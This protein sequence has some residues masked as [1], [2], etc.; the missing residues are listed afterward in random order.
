MSDRPSRPPLLRARGATV[1]YGAVG[2]RAVTALDALDLEIPGA[3]ITCLLGANGAGKTTLL[4]AASGLRR[5]TSG[6]LEVLG[7]A[8]GSPAN[9]QELGVM[10]QDG[11]LPGSARP[12]EFLSYV[13]RLY[14]RPRDVAEVMAS[15]EIADCAR[16]PI[17]RLS[18]GQAK[19]VA[20][21]AAMIGD[22]TAMILDEPTTALDPIGR[23]RMHEV[24]EAQ[25]NCGSALVLSTHLIED[26]DALA[27][28]IV[29]MREGRVVLSGTPEELRPRNRIEL[30]APSHLDVDG[31]LGALPTGSTCSEITPGR[32]R[33]QVPG[34]IDPA[35]VATLTSWCAQHGVAPDVSIADLGSVLRDAIAG[36]GP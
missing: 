13:S 5:L 7:C 10:L 35:S 27:D 32:Y 9:R 36:Q 12:A 23:A 26:V 6:D 34:D 15:V 17:R 28:Y 25:R 16:T 21:A 14:P 30:R 3:G 1:R 2:N 4:E 31:L 20:W 33:V 24:L 18:G 8:P 11:G 22:P 19:R 29:V